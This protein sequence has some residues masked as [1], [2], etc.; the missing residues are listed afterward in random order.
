MKFGCCAPIGLYDKVVQAGYDYMDVNGAALYALSDGE[1]E[2]MVKKVTDGPIPCLALSG[3]AKDEPK[4]AGDGF[5]PDEVRK[6][7][8]KVLLRAAGLGVKL[9]G[10]GSPAIRRLPEDYDRKKAWE[11]GKQFIEITADVAESYGMIVMLESLHKYLC[12]FCNTLDEAYDMVREINRPNV[13]LVIDYYNI[14]PMTDDIYDLRKYLPETVHLHTSGMG[15]NY[16]RPQLKEKDYDELKAIFRSLKDMGYDGAMSNES[17]NSKLET[18][19]AR[20]V[21]IM[22]RAYKDA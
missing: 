22:R 17:D 21:E 1:Y 8:K 16:S 5:D 4:M 10:I 13:K 3:Y 20:A 12:N 19:G 2:E 9:I 11:Q 15:E 18:E 7:A 6:Y 14:K